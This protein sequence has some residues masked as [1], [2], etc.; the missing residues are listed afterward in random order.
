MSANGAV[1]A[2]NIWSAGGTPAPYQWKNGALI[3][4]PGS[5]AN[6]S[7]AT[8]VSP[9]GSVVVGSTFNGRDTDPFEWTNGVVTTLTLPSGFADGT[10][11]GVSNDG[12]TMVGFMLPPLSNDSKAFI[13]TQTNAVQDLQ[14]VLT[15]DGLGSELAGW[16]L[17]QATAIT[18]DGNTIVGNGTDL[19]GQQ[20]G[21]IVNL[22]SSPP[23]QQTPTITWPVPADIVYGTALSSMQL[24][25]TASYTANGNTVSV[26]GTFTYSPP[27]G[28]VL[29]AGY[30]QRLSV[31]FTPTDAID[32]TTATGSTTISVH[33]ATP[34]VT[35]ANPADIVY[36]M[37]L[38]DAQLDATASYTVNGN[39]VIVAGTF[40]YSPPKGAVLPAGNNQT[41]LVSF[42]PT[43]TTDYTSATATATINVLQA[44]PPGGQPPGV[45][46]HGT[47]T[48]VTAKPRSSTV[49]RLIIVTA[50]VENI[51]HTGGVPT[52]VVNFLDSFRNILG[53]SVP[54]RHGKA[55]L[56]TSGLPVGRDTIQVDYL[57]NS[58]FAPSSSDIFVT[59]R[60][61]RSK[62]KATVPL[63]LPWSKH[64]VTS[65]ATVSGAGGGMASLSGTAPFLDG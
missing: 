40:T 1:V 53:F 52:G 31:S 10:P 59:I 44:K 12:T 7:T 55:M 39:P 50:R 65:T 26:A 54:L 46:V 51:S 49:G 37:A 25:A 3:Q 63:A 35:W 56:R 11:L 18:P 57:G 64:S 42:T 16:T 14:Q 61:R 2:G 8:A 17:T 47:K 9:D 45:G 23:H 6:S 32:Y 36:G 41:L 15:A 58:S 19:Q 29:S 28:T 34:T 20:E 22:S 24:D 62:A 30:N 27:K 60:P 13:W 33:Q 21:W 43:D 5:T 48:I 4:W 38:G